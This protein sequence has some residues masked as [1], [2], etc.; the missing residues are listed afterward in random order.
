MAGDADGHERLAR[1]SDPGS[2]IAV[3]S[4]PRRHKPANATIELFSYGF[5][6]GPIALADGQAVTLKFMSSAAAGHDITAPS[7]LF[8]GLQRVAPSLPWKERSRSSSREGG[9]TLR[10]HRRPGGPARSPRPAADSFDWSFT[11]AGRL[12]ID[13]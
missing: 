5:R 7:E 6:P 4:L 1:G 10:V 11:D 2:A 13:G 12:V 8:A 3:T 9:G